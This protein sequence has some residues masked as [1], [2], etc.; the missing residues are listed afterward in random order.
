MDEMIQLYIND[1]LIS[2]LKGTSVAAT[3]FQAQLLNSRIPVSGEKRAAFCG[4]GI[5]Q[6]CRV[7]IQGR[8]V[9]ACQTPCQHGMKVETLQ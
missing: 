6:E 1:E 4:M 3:I 2:V 7:K 5:C 9:L 8:R